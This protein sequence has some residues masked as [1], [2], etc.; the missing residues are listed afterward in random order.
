MEKEDYLIRQISQL[1]RVLGKI[2]ASLLGLK[3]S[4]QV[5]SGIEAANLELKNESGLNFDELASIPFESFLGKFPPAGKLN[6]DNFEMLADIL[7]LLAEELNGGDPDF[8]KRKRLLERSLEIYEYINAVSLVY[9]VERNLKIVKL[10][11]AI[12]NC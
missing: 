1:G 11:L 5:N 9:S 4:G 2:L 7:F 6:C 3:A 10:K 8:E 12:I